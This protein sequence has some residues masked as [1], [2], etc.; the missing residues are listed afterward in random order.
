M[1]TRPARPGHHNAILGSGVSRRVRRCVCA[2]VG[3]RRNFEVFTRFWRA[4]YRKIRS[5]RSTPASGPRAGA[6]RFLTRRIVA[7]R[8]G[9]SRCGGV[10]VELPTLELH[11]GGLGFVRARLGCVSLPRVASLCPPL[12]FPH[13]SE[14]SFITSRTNTATH[15]RPHQHGRQQTPQQHTPPQHTPAHTLL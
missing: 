12:V 2:S 15:H 14:P 4:P 6:R 5:G 9:A 8:P 11:C 13:T 3:E 1:W 10:C 7:R